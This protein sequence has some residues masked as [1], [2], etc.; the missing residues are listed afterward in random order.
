MLMLRRLP[1]PHG[2]NGSQI[3]NFDF[4]ANSHG[5]NSVDLSQ[6]YRDLIVIKKL[7]MEE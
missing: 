2:L 3:K 4:D 7:T 5:F 1:F 6:E